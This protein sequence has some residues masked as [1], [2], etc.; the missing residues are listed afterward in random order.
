MPLGCYQQGEKL[1]IHKPGV[2]WEPSGEVL[3]AGQ[4]GVSVAGREGGHVR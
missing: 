3:Q 1:G 2:G 4:V